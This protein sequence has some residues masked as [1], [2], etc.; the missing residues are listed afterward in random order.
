MQRSVN[1]KSDTDEQK[2]GKHFVIQENVIICTWIVLCHE[3][4]NPGS[5]RLFYAKT[6]RSLAFSLHRETHARSIFIAPLLVSKTMLFVWFCRPRLRVRRATKFS[7]TLLSPSQGAGTVYVNSS[8]RQLGNTEDVS[9]LYLQSARECCT[10][11]GPHEGH[12]LRETEF[13]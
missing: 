8:T 2:E 4:I 3:K 12:L 5:L 11:E 1:L 7:C 13:H 6:R 10:A 9:M